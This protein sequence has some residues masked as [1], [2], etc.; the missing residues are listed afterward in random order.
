[1]RVTIRDA[2]HLIEQH[3]GIGM[4]WC[5][6]FAVMAESNNLLIKM[7]VETLSREYVFNANQ[8]KSGNWH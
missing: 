1:M 6:F 3:N 5:S 8:V 2:R 4:K 7:G